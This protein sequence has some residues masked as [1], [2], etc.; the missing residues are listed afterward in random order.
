MNNGWGFLAL[1]LVGVGWQLLTKW[2][3]TK[4]WGLS[5][6]TALIA[7]PVPTAGLL[8]GI[9]IC[10]AFIVVNPNWRQNLNNNSLRIAWKEVVIFSLWTFAGFL[11]TL[12]FFFKLKL[13]GW[14]EIE[15]C[16]WF[17][18]SFLFVLEICLL[19][20]IARL[21]PGWS[22]TGV[23]VRMGFL[24]FLFLLYWLYPYGL[25]LEGLTLLTLVVT[26]PILLGWLAFSQNNDDPVS[27]GRNK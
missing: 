9:W 23:G 15:Q 4:N 27:R 10:A 20:I 1:L 12:L 26:F 16:Q 18:W 21:I 6:L 14:Y 17:A 13:S 19:R 7:P 2:T 8:T 11:I 24:N 22:R 3:P 5:F 25:I